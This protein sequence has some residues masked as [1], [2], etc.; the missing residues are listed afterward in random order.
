M[1]CSV[2]LPFLKIWYL[3]CI[4]RFDTTPSCFSRNIELYDFSEKAEM[5]F[6]VKVS[7][8][9]LHN[10]DIIFHTQYSTPWLEL[11]LWFDVSPLVWPL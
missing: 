6:H 2:K 9:Q 4:Y 5:L 3:V 10:D 8:T 1:F 11:F 7:T